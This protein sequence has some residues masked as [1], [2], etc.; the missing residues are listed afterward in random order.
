MPA[1]CESHKKAGKC[2]KCHSCVSCPA[3]DSCIRPN[4][5]RVSKRKA[6]TSNAREAN[7]SKE[8]RQKK[9]FESSLV[10]PTPNLET[11]D[12][13][14]RDAGSTSQPAYDF[15]DQP[16]HL[17]SSS[18][19][20]TEPDERSLV[21]AQ[22]IDSLPKKPYSDK[23]LD[24]GRS[25]VANTK[26]EICTILTK[27]ALYLSSEREHDVLSIM[28]SI[29][30]APTALYDGLVTN[31]LHLIYNGTARTKTILL[32]ILAKSLT[33]EDCNKILENYTGSDKNLI[34]GY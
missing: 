15:A 31:M 18:P 4:Q 7:P 30:E 23:S 13:L 5:H 28:A 6:R 14:D 19:V 3:P 2:N 34:I 8:K 16:E 21:L 26:K 9:N 10:I 20:R 29:F 11:I 24:G 17:G 22:L 1:D 27:L 25:S 12:Q 32:S 33:F